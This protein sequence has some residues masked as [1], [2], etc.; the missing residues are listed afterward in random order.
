MYLNRLNLEQKEL[1]LDLCIHASLSNNNF[2]S[3]E[4][5]AIEQYCAE[6]QLPLVR[7]STEKTVDEAVNRILEIST[8]EELR[9]ILLEITALIISDNVFDEREQKFMND[10]ADRIGFS[11]G[12]LDE[13]LGCLNELTEVYKKI[14]SI[15]FKS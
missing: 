7:Y 15:I 11:K 3:E 9:I 4:K 5:H 1:F 12:H 2:A 6:M 8:K 13:M 14:N 10:L